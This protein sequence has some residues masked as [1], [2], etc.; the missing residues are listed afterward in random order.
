V[1]NNSTQYLFLLFL[2][3][4]A[5]QL[6]SMNVYFK[7]QD[8]VKLTLKWTLNWIY[9]SIE[10]C[11]CCDLNHANIYTSKQKQYMPIRLTVSVYKQ[12][13]QNN[14]NERS[15]ETISR[16][17]YATIL[18]IDI[19]TLYLQ[20]TGYKWLCPIEIYPRLIIL[21]SPNH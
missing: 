8:V 18:N 14:N 2:K 10:G 11:V 6:F 13:L 5:Y 9:K 20:S 1:V 21:L 7:T 19:K 4:F 3:G 16:T 12:R 15:H 17:H